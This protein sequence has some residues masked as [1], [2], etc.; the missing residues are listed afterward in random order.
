[1]HRCRIL[2]VHPLECAGE[3]VPAAKLVSLWRA[4]NVSNETLDANGYQGSRFEP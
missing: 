3:P 4:F 2:I 1:M